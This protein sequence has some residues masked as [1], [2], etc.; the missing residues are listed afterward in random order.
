MGGGGLLMDVCV[1]H[2]R[3]TIVPA[4]YARWY[5]SGSVR[6][7]PY[8]TSYSQE[9]RQVGTRAPPRNHLRYGGLFA[10]ACARYERRNA[11]TFAIGAFSLPSASFSFCYLLYLTSCSRALY[12]TTL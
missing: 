12:Y 1:L 6:H 11:V 3:K 2:I 9:M 8:P 7:L 4:L 10:H 5:S